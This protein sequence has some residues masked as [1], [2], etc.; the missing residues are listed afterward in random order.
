LEIAR[1]IQ[2]IMC[3]KVAVKH[4]SSSSSSSSSSSVYSI[5]IDMGIL[6]LFDGR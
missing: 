4:Q 3:T 2:P 5:N 1:P 6:H